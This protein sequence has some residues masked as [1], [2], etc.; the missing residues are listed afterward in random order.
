MQKIFIRIP[1]L[2]IKLIFTCPVEKTIAL[3]GVDI[4]I[5]KAQLAA[6][7][8][9]KIIFTTSNPVSMAKVP[10]KGRS[11][12]VVAVL[13]VNSVKKHVKNV[14][15]NIIKKISKFFKNIMFLE[16]SLANPVSITKEAI[17]SP[18][19]NSIKT[20]QG[21]FLNQSALR[22][23]LYFLFTGIT[24]NKKAQNK[25]IPESLKLISKI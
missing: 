3:G 8:T 24:K 11:K 9:G 15:N 20:F 7:T 6:K 1:V 5:I 10:S 18:P 13:L 23:V 17:A 25:A 19:P 16:I 14:K 21:I 22:I 2:T 12:K 4:G